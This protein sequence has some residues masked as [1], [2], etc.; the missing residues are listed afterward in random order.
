MV[1]V[2][3]SHEDQLARFEAIDPKVAQEL[4]SPARDEAFDLTAMS[5]ALNANRWRG[6]IPLVVLTHGKVAPAPPG[7]EAISEGL[8]K[9]WLDMQRELAARSPASTHIVAKSGHY[10]HREEPALVIDAVR[11]ITDSRHG[12]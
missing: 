1:L 3:S 9:A 8:E 12:R 6:T 10:I 5:A 11:R 7:R 4:R 2:D